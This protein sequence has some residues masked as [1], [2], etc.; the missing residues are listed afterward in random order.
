MNRRAVYW[1]GAGLSLLLGLLFWRLGLPGGPLFQGL[2]ILLA[3]F[4]FW[5]GAALLLGLSGQK[6]SRGYRLIFALI[7]V[8]YCA[9]VAVSFLFPAAVSYF[10]VFTLVC[11]AGLTQFFE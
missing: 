1:A 4:C 7:F 10:L 6:Y 2:L 8:G 9:M 5:N 3:P 11:L